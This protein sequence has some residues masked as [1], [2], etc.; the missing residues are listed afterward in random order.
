MRKFLFVLS[1]CF[2]AGLNLLYGQGIEVTG[3]VTGAGD[4]S[5]LPGVSVVV[6]GTTIGS[7]TDYQGGYFHQWEPQPHHCGG[8]HPC[9]F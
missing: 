7:V 6:K 3:K 2:I 9:G 4:G 1:L 8:W 5:A